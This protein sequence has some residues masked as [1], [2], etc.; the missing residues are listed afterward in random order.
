MGKILIVDD[1]LESLKLMGMM[2]QGRGHQ[3]IAAQSGLQALNKASEDLPDIIILDVMM[4][5]MDGLE[6]CRRLRA[7]PRTQHIPVIMFTAKSQVDDKVAGFEAGADEYLTKPIHPAEL[8]TRVEALLARAARM[9]AKPKVELRAKLLGFLGCKGGVG[10][11]TVAMNVAVALAEGPAHGK[12]VVLAEFRDSSSSLGLQLGLPTHQGLAS[13]LERKGSLSPEALSAQLERHLSGVWVMGG[14][15]APLA[16]HA[17]I[18]LKTGETMTYAL[19][20]FA[21]YLLLDMG[22]GLSDLNQ[23]LLRL[24]R[25]LFVVTEPQM[26]AM[27]MTQTLLATLT[28]LE[29]GRHK[30]GIVLVHKAPSATTMTK[31]VVED[32]LQREVVGILSPAPELAFQAAERGV[33]MV[34]A[35]PGSLVAQ[36]VRQ[37]AEFAASL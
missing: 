29:F 16:A 1:D 26:V 25:Y 14:V 36:Q 11:T 9:G 17:P 15:S 5:G 22:M 20:Q 34:L 32:K 30:V 18:D 10:T 21:D 23:M 6:V 3:I 8:T 19:G 2:F 7:D 12:N 24:L 35:Q 13:L 27:Q 28:A 37:L 31:A 4:P 33:P